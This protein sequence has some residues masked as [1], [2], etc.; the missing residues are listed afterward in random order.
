[1][2]AVLNTAQCIVQIV[3]I[4]VSKLQLC[5]ISGAPITKQIFFIFEVCRHCTLTLAGI[6]SSY[7]CA[8]LLAQTTLRAKLRVSRALWLAALTTSAIR[9]FFVTVWSAERKLAPALALAIYEY[10]CAT[11]LCAT[12]S[13]R[14]PAP[15]TAILRRLLGAA[16]LPFAL[17]RAIWRTFAAV[18]ATE[19]L[20]AFTLAQT[21]FEDWR[22]AIRSIACATCITPGEEYACHAHEER[23][24]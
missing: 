16:V 11:A 1:M 7:W 13:P 23:R 2:S 20:L 24:P 12:R 17:W 8:S 14:F 3:T 10:W 21:I 5:I 6:A 9:L 15:R 22:P 4:D 19:R 18:R